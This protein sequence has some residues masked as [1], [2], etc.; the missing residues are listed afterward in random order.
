MAASSTAL[1]TPEL[2][3]MILSF[4]D[5]LELIRLQRVCRRFQRHLSSTRALRD[6]TFLEVD[7]NAVILNDNTIKGHEEK[8]SGT[9]RPNPFLKHIFRS[10]A[11]RPNTGH[12]SNSIHEKWSIEEQL[13][14]W[15]EQNFVL[16][17]L[18]TPLK[19]KE[20][21]DTLIASWRRMTFTQPPV[22]GV[23]VFMGTPRYRD[24]KQP[25]TPDYGIVSNPEGVRL[26]DIYD[27]IRAR[28]KTPWLEAS[29]VAVAVLQLASY[30][31]TY[32][33][34]YHAFIRYKGPTTA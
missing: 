12:D 5:P 28:A 8:Y 2:L 34:C 19:L 9:L 4:C 13:A 20:G 26:G 31:R 24:D 7:K 11:D 27:N 22:Y 3:D 30:E 15:E 23:A 10:P 25:R 29:P 21:W 14:R 17:H 32:S 18:P 1:A 33:A 16:L 6:C